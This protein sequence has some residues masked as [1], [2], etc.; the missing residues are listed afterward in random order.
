[1][2][3]LEKG[4]ITIQDLTTITIGTG[5]TG[6]TI[7]IGGGINTGFTTTD[8]IIT[9]S[10]MMVVIIVHLLDRRLNQK[11]DQHQ[12]QYQELYQNQKKI[13]QE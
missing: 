13:E 6:D 9:A 5:T 8:I 10:I 3:L 12:E 4:M 11:E 7:S 2:I 1:M